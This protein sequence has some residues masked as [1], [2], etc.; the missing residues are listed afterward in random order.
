MICINDYYLIPKKR[1]SPLSNIAGVRVNLTLKTARILTGSRSN[2]AAH[3]AGSEKWQ[4]SSG[5]AVAL[6][7]RCR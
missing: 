7:Q 5:F 2:C 6:L 1:L 3:S 4:D